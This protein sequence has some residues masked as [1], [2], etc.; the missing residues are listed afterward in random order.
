M[1]TLN[2]EMI[3]RRDFFRGSGTRQ[4][5]VAVMACPVCGCKSFF[6]KDPNNAHEVYSFDLEAGGVVFSEDV[7]ATQCPEVGEDTPIECSDCAWHGRFKELK[8]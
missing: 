6:L 8:G 5:E 7:E 4:Q 1:D 3:R 2:A